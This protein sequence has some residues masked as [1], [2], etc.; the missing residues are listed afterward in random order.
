MSSSPE[1]YVVKRKAKS[2]SRKTASPWTPVPPARRGSSLGT[3]ARHND[4]PQS[5]SPEMLGEVWE[6]A[7][8][9]WSAFLGPY[10]P[11]KMRI[12]LGDFPTCAQAEAAIDARL[13]EE[14]WLLR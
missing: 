6:D 9:R 11:G 13:S 5:L 8:H 7:G 3:F 2:T 1:V 14:G 4:K 10:V 12:K